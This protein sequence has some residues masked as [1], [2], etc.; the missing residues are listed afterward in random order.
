ML[1]TI[2]ESASA[3]GAESIAPMRNA[4]GGAAALASVIQAQGATIDVVG[5]I[6]HDIAGYSLRAALS[7][8]GIDAGHLI[9][10]ADSATLH[11]LFEPIAA[12]AANDFDYRARFDEEWACHYSA[13]AQRRLQETCLA[14]IRRCDLVICLDLGYGAVSSDLWRQLDGLRRADSR[15]IILISASRHTHRLDEAVISSSSR[16]LEY[17]P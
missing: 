9:E 15:S 1:H 12:T 10:D 4:P 3:M 8:R 13:R 6:G 14:A 17:R 2:R 16:S 7:E 5:I 11:M